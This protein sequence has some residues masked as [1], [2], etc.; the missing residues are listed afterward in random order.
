MKT[1]ILSICLFLLNLG[2][3]YAQS[4]KQPMGVIL[5]KHIADKMRDTL[6]LNN[7]QTGKI[8]AIN[9]QLHEQKM[10]A[11]KSSDSRDSIGKQIQII[12]NT[13]DGF[14]KEVLTVEQFIIYKQ[15]KRFLINRG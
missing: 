11:M 6:V 12:E 9:I 5:A 1:I 4:N 7:I 15:K 10:K 2:S 3:A 13:R 8:Q 14:Y